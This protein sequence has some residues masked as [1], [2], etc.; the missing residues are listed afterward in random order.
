MIK[1]IVDAISQ[2][3]AFSKTEARGTFILAGI[4]ILAITSFNLVSSKMKDKPAEDF[5]PTELSKWVNEV[6]ASYSRK[7]PVVKKAKLQTAL[8]TNTT[9][10]SSKPRPVSKP[11]EKPELVPVVLDLNTASAEELQRVRGIGK[12]YSE[13]IVKYRELLGGFANSRQLLEVYGIT[14]ELVNSINKSFNVQTSTT[15]I[16]FNVDSAKHLAKHPYISYDLAWVIINY[17]KQNGDIKTLEDLL[18]VKALDDSVLQKLKPY[19]K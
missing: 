9:S 16:N 4:V 3:L 5:D 7:K 1:F 14:E 2:G 18:L 15:F 17:R 12:V 10:K 8:P 19:V 13:R 11:S 6:E